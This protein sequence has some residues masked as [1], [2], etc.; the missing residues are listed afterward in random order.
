MRAFWVCLSRTPGSRSPLRFAPP[1]FAPLRIQGTEGGRCPPFLSPGASPAPNKFNLRHPAPQCRHRPVGSHPGWL[2]L[3]KGTTQN[4]YA[5]H[6]EVSGRPTRPTRSGFSPTHPPGHTPIWANPYRPLYSAERSVAS[7]A[8]LALF[9]IV[10]NSTLGALYLLQGLDVHARPV[11]YYPRA[12][13]I[14]SMVTGGPL[15]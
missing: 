7:F 14:L 3:F 13:I 4:T 10:I 6:P 9:L 5:L 2:Q 1:R 15:I 8:A 11:P 12:S